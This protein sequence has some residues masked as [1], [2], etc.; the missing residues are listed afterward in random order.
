VTFQMYLTLPSMEGLVGGPNI[1][2]VKVVSG[3]ITKRKNQNLWTAPQQGTP[4]RILRRVLIRGNSG[5][6]TLCKG[7]PSRI[8]VCKG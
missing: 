7:Q 4:V 8:H 1:S 2:P 6:W 5:V 3:L